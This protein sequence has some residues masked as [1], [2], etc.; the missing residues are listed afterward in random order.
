MVESKEPAAIDTNI[1]AGTGKQILKVYIKSNK[2]RPL[3]K[4]IN[5]VLSQKKKG[6]LI[7]LSEHYILLTSIFSKY[8]FIRSLQNQGINLDEL[9]Q[10]YDSIKTYFK[11]SE[12]TFEEISNFINHKFFEDILRLNISL[13]DGLQI[14]MASR[15]VRGR[16]GLIFITG[17]ERHAL[18]MKKLYSDVFTVKEIYKKLQSKK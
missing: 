8:E 2:R 12:L 6:I 4:V 14:L 13:S 18:N 17:N 16:K 10:I 11:I 7:T 3:Y 1:I 15:K 9:R 5:E